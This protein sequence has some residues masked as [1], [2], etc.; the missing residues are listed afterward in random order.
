MR[1]WRSYVGVGCDAGI[2][3]YVY[4]AAAGVT[5]LLA[6]AGDGSVAE[7]LSRRRD[8]PVVDDDTI[9]AG[10]EPAILQEP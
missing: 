3:A 2:G 10:R 4:V 6:L 5:S 9:T 7:Q 1:R 8:N